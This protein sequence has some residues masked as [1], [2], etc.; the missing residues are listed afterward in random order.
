M[1]SQGVWPEVSEG[2]VQSG[3][4]RQGQ[5]WWAETGKGVESQ[6]GEDC[7]WKTDGCGM[8]RRGLESV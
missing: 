1:V 7:L 5:M 4:A 8:K 2:R 6:D 3:V